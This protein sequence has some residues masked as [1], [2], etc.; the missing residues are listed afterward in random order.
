MVLS[1]DNLFPE[2]LV[3]DFI[4]KVKGYS[5]IAKLCNQEPIPFNGMK[6]FTFTMDKEVDIVAEN[7]KKSEGGI[8]VEPITIIPLKI[9][10]GARVSDEFKYGAEEYRLNVLKSFA[11]GFAK[12]SGAAVDYMLMH[13]VNPRTGQASDIIGDNC[14]DKKVTQTVNFNEEDPDTNIE[15]AVGLIRGSDGDV[16]GAAFDPTFSSALS[17][18]KVNGVKQFPELSW[19]ANPGTVNGLPVDINKTVGK[20]GKD[21]AIVG[22]F[23][24]MIKWGYAKQI[25]LKVI[26]YGDPD[27]SG[28]D[29]QGHNQVY[30]R[31]EAYI[32][33]GIF[34]PEQFARIVEGAETA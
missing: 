3:G 12:K 4:S 2:V 22:N 18:I 1:R 23:R 19:G 34:A 28:Q 33:W 21:K 27:N 13:G 14:L 30:I 29:L 7:G 11:D 20:F 6:E 26:E 17:K 9:E 31:C 16:S 24:D 5:S 10:Y 32:G 15:T 25:P 8:S